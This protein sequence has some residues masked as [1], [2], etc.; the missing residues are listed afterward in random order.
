MLC[1]FDKLFQFGKQ[2]L[3]TGLSVNIGEVKSWFRFADWAYLWGRQLLARFIPLSSLD[4][5]QQVRSI[6]PSIC[7]F[8]FQLGYRINWGSEHF[9]NGKGNFLRVVQFRIEQEQG[10]DDNTAM[11]SARFKCCSTF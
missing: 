2:Y 10:K 7:S 5:G 9:C 1:Q 11:N 8:S 6:L 3:I 4:L